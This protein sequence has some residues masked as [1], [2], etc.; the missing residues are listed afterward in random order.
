MKCSGDA[1]VVGIEDVPAV[2]VNI[3]A[4]NG[5][6]SADLLL[7]MLHFTGFYIPFCIHIDVRR[8]VP[9][10]DVSGRL[11]HMIQLMPPFLDADA[12]HGKGDDYVSLFDKGVV[13]IAA[14]HACIGRG[15]DCSSR[16]VESVYF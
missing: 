10:L 3:R 14:V 13:E 16:R 9:D 7:E 6:L 12:T 8:L 11:D 2:P 1:A 4:E 15:A 5:D